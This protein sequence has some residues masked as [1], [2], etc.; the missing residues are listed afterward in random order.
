[1]LA[2]TELAR[3][4]W[5]IAFLEYQELTDLHPEDPEGWIGLGGLMLKTGLLATSEAAP[6]DGCE[7]AFGVA[8]VP[9][10]RVRTE[11]QAGGG[12]LAS[13]ARE[14]WPGRMAQMR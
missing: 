10:G 5:E 7:R 1:R 3:G 11:T 12:K 8:P 9:A 4:Q 2:E 6:P 13:L 14:H